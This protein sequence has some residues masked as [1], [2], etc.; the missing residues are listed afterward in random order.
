M[1]FFL[2]FDFKFIGLREQESQEQEHNGEK[3]VS[4]NYPKQQD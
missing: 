4:T 3:S 2:F 1:S